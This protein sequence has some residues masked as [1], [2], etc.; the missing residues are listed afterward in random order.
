MA[1]EFASNFTSNFTLAKTLALKVSER[2][3]SMDDDYFKVFDE[4]LLNLGIV[5]RLPAFFDHGNHIFIPHRPV[6]RNDD[7]V[8]NSISKS[9][10][11]CF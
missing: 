5:E 8:K 3:G 6:I 11:N 1:T 10:F 9:I 7:L 4:Q 2:N